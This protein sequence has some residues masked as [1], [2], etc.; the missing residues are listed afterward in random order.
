MKKCCTTLIVL[1]AA[2]TV[3]YLVITGMLVRDYFRGQVAF[4]VLKTA[5]SNSATYFAVL[6]GLVIGYAA[7]LEQRRPRVEELVFHPMNGDKI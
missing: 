6:V 5:C 3:G 2:L 4:S 7:Y 1:F